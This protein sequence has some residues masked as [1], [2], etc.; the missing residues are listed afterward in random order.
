VR[1][2]QANAAKVTALPE[3][4]PPKSYLETHN[5]RAPVGSEGFLEFGDDVLHVVLGRDSKVSLQKLMRE[6]G[7]K[8]TRAAVFSASAQDGIEALEGELAKLKGNYRKVYLHGHGDDGKKSLGVLVAIDRKQ[9]NGVETIV[10][11]KRFSAEDLYGMLTNAGIRFG[12]TEIIACKAA[13]DTA[14]A[15]SFARQWRSL[16]GRQ[17]TASEQFMRLRGGRFTSNP[18]RTGDS[19][20]F[21]PNNSEY[22]PN[23]ARVFRAYEE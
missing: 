3:P 18:H 2:I 20:N 1:G 22:W 8:R 21:N 14:S 23:G 10:G 5:V 12:E 4:S 19:A 9:S 6:Q 13:V 16:S 11:E 15:P 7:V 17:T